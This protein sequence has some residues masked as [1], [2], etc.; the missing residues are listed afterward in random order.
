MYFFKYVRLIAHYLIFCISIP[1]I[2]RPDLCKREIRTEFSW[3]FQDYF[4]K[5]KFFSK[6]FFMWF[7]SFFT[8]TL[9]SCILHGRTH[10]AFFSSEKRR[11]CYR[12][13]C[14]SVCPCVRL[15][16]RL[17]ANFLAYHETHRTTIFS[18]AP[19]ICMLET[20]QIWFISDLALRINYKKREK[21]GWKKRLMRI[22]S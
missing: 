15:S 4:K 21:Q 1:L 13:V 18:F 10:L 20:I 6:L 17:W 22:T 11:L 3:L 9:L 2:L 8:Y 5:Y 19:S 7:R 16:I 12:C 14:L